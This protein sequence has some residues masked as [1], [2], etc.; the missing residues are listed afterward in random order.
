MTAAEY[1]RFTKAAALP[2]MMPILLSW[3]LIA[4]VMYLV[5][6][7]SYWF[8]IL[9]LP[10]IAN[11]QLALCLLAH[12]GLHGNLAPSRFWSDW[13][14]RYICA[15]PVFVSLSRYRAKHMMHHK[16]VGTAADPDFNLFAVYPLTRK[17]FV[18]KVLA[19]FFSLRMLRDFLEYYTDIPRF[20]RGQP[21][22]NGAPGSVF[23][24]GDFPQFI[25]FQLALWAAVI[26]GGV[27]HWYLLLWFVPLL[28]SLPY[29]RF[30]G[31]LQHGPMRP[32]EP[33]VMRSR[34]ILGPKWL[35]EILLPVNINYHAEH[36][37]EGAVPQYRLPE[38]S[39]FLIQRGE[40]IWAENYSEALRA[41]FKS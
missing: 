3:A 18:L 8:Y 40:K 19:D 16:L 31:A 36:H 20:L 4:F 37:I 10:V 24:T 25:L 29:I 13:V 22:L 34:T 17:E 28:C 11:R 23:G 30:M 41:L 35:M 21:S 27:W 26:V 14:G 6:G 39:E 5:I 12:E 1:E 15:F 7:V 33:E 2:A 32:K 38:F 9:A